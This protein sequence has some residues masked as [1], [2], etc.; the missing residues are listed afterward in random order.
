MFPVGSNTHFLPLFRHPTN[1]TKI[2]Y[3]N[4]GIDWQGQKCITLMEEGMVVV[5]IISHIKY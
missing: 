3:F 5:V 4:N 1:C 2:A